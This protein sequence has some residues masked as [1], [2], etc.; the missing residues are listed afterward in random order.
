VATAL[1]AAERHRVVHRNITP[2]AILFTAQGKAKLGDFSLAKE[3]ADAMRS[4]HQVLT[5]AGQ[6]I[7]EYAFT[8]PEAL[9]ETAEPDLRGD[10]YSLACCVYQAIAGRPPY[11][12]RNSPELIQKVLHAEVESVRRFNDKAS[13]ELDAVLLKALARN[14]KDRQQSPAELLY[15]LDR[16]ALASEH[17]TYN[18]R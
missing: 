13:P 4:I 10:I 16:L 8:A 12:A 14:P 2:S 3:S 1:E 6:V 5:Q 18:I 17:Q 9:N 15:E 7:G 11:V